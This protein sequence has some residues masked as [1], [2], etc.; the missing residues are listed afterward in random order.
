[1]NRLYVGAIVILS[2]VRPTLSERILV[3]HPPD[4]IYDLGLTIY[5]R[6]N[7]SGINNSISRSVVNIGQSR[8]RETHKRLFFAA[9]PITP[10]DAELGYPCY[11]TSSDQSA[12][13]T[14]TAVGR[15]VR[16]YVDLALVT[17]TSL[18]A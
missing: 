13:I 1:M 6:G 4:S 5:Q 18:Q 11:V 14:I 3:L 9:E 8:P 10:L 12:E 7:W 15:D 16:A 2:C 17:R